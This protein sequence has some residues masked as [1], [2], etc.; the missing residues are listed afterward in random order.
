MKHIVKKSEPKAFTDWKAIA[1][2]DWQPSYNELSGNTKQAVK[3][4]LMR[5]QGWLC[6]YCERRVSDED[7]HIEHFRP[8]ADP[9]V[10]SLDFSN[11]LCSCHNQQETREPRHCG[12][13]KGSWF[14]S[15]LLISPLDT[16]CESRF[17]YLHDGT[18]EP[19]TQNDTAARTTIE[20][21]GLNTQ[22][23]RASRADTITPFSIENLSNDELSVLVSDYL[24]MDS[25]GRHGEFYT[26]IKYL[27]A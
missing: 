17:R 12:H 24:A 14:D 3:E 21:L 10:D 1:N 27:F 25:S 5:E 4:A 9:N 6:C 11:L 15:K 22:K 26:T 13:L 19:S 7:S 23:L 16:S 8:Q 20:K 2:E 18:I